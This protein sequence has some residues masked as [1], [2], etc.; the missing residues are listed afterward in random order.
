MI[1]REQFYL[2]REDG[3]RGYNL[4]YLRQEDVQA[5]IAKGEKD[6]DWHWEV[7]A[8]VVKNGTVESRTPFRIRIPEP[9]PTWDD[10]PVIR[11]MKEEKAKQECEDS[12]RR[13]IEEVDKILEASS[14][15]VRPCQSNPD[16]V[17]E[18]TTIRQED[19]TVTMQSIRMPKWIHELGAE[20]IRAR[21]EQD[22]DFLIKHGVSF[23]GFVLNEPDDQ[24]VVKKV[25]IYTQEKRKEIEK[26]KAEKRYGFWGSLLRGLRK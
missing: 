18:E 26:A 16:Y 21:R 13:A 2:V 25:H 14:T 9:H 11:Y 17:I 22:P 23:R 12:A 20:E 1:D 10:D 5:E 8:D 6:K 24:P 19:G 7:F 15:K 3:S 4:A